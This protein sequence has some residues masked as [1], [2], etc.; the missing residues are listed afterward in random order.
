MREIGVM[1]KPSKLTIETLCCPTL[2]DLP[3]PPDGKSGWPWTE[4]SAKVPDK[5]PDGRLWPKISIVTPSYNQGQ[6]IEEAIRSILL[7]GYPD[8]EYIIIDGGSTDR[9][10]E[11]IKK[12]EP[13]LAYWESKP[14]KGQ[15]HAINKGLEKS[16]GK[17]FNWHNSDDILMPDSLTT[18]A[19]AMLEHPEAGYI[20][21]KRIFID[22]AGNVW[23]GNKDSYNNTVSFSPELAESVSVLKTGCQ[24]TCLMDRDLVIQAGRVDENLHYIMDI[25]LL[26]RIAL[27][28]P[29]IHIDSPMT[30]VRIHPDTKS[31]QWNSQRARERIY[32]AN[33]IFSREGLPSPIVKLRKQTLATA[34]RFAWRSYIRAGKYGSALRHLLLDIFF[35]SGREWRKRLA[36]YRL[37]KLDKKVTNFGEKI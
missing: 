23:G 1:R 24:P 17:L 30:Y 34:H 13:W 7:Q 28:K 11:I 29:P 14:D 12:Y 32:V 15:S 20:H 33:K 18:I 9:T 26:L 37:L 3:L 6:F 16:T 4:E 22:E 8:L 5:M 19:R 27:I 2:E 35:S 31:L 36:T 10:V 25:D 21:G